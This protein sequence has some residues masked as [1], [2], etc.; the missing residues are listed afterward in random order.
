MTARM[1]SPFRKHPKIRGAV[2]VFP[3]TPAKRSF[4]VLALILL[5]TAGCAP[6]REDTRSPRL[7]VSILPQR[8]LVRQIAGD[9]FPIDV[10]I[11][12]GYS[13]ATYSPTPGQI[14]NLAHS[15][16]WFRIGYIPFEKFWMK[17]IA[18]NNPE[19][20]IVDTS[21]GVFMIRKGP[22]HKDTGAHSGVDPHIWLSPR[23]VSIQAGNIFR[24]LERID[25][26][27]RAEY[28]TNHDRLQREISQLDAL[29]SLRLKNLKTRHFLVFHPSWAYFARDYGLE[30]VSIEVEGKSPRPM[31]LARTIARA[32]EMGVH[33]VFVQKQFDTA[34]AE[35][36]AR[37]IRGRVALLDPLS[38][39]W[40][41]NLLAVARALEDRKKDQEK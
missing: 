40:P 19:L 21:T 20:R 34:A 22:D 6:K 10:L 29:L 28:R 39:D 15:R 16:A 2:A 13:P 9:R 27:N 24:A 14:R 3:A 30:Q 1:N 41:G 35:V 5:M 8:Y 38:E 17:R 4:I 32:R 25:P 33:T 37:E 36:V 7:A 23:A 18:D 11:P 31:D 12:P 26:S